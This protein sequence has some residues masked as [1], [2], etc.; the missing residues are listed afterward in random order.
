MSDKDAPSPVGRFFLHVLAVIVTFSV[1]RYVAS[2]YKFDPEDYAVSFSFFQWIPGALLVIPYCYVAYI[3]TQLLSDDDMGAFDWDS[4][5][6]MRIGTCFVSFIAV[7]LSLFI[8]SWLWTFESFFLY[9]V[10]FPFLIVSIAG[11]LGM[12]PWFYVM[13]L[14]L[15][16]FVA[17]V[18]Y[19]SNNPESAKLAFSHSANDRPNSVIEAELA[20][21]LSREVIDVTAVAELIGEL[22]PWAALIQ[23]IKYRSYAKKL[24]EA[25]AAMKV[26]RDAVAAATNVAK[27]AHALEKEKRNAEG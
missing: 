11:L 8:M 17:G 13:V 24:R 6:S 15:P 14:E 9:V 23:K 26:Q 20:E 22:P 18:V 10:S 27:E 1:F 12:F 4:I 3:G 16:N 21:A 5:T 19:I 2:D 25:T 7:W